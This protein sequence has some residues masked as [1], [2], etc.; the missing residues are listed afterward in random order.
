MEDA[1]VLQRHNI[2]TWNARHF[3]YDLILRF[4]NYNHQC[5]LCDRILDSA[6]Q[7]EHYL[8][9]SHYLEHHN[10]TFKK[11]SEAFS[12]ISPLHFSTQLHN[13]EHHNKTRTIQ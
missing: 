13:L 5:H 12:T 11:A 7:C 3:Y 1:K 4:E 8:L 2:A 9:K 6:N 10:K